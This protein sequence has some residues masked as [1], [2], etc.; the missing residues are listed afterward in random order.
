MSELNYKHQW[1]GLGFADMT[2]AQAEEWVTVSG[3][4]DTPLELFVRKIV[5]F[6][7]DQPYGEA[8]EHCPRMGVGEPGTRAETV[9]PRLLHHWTSLM[10][11]EM[12]EQEAEGWMSDEGRDL[13][14]SPHSLAV[15][16]ALCGDPF[17]HAGLVCGERAVYVDE[18]D[19]RD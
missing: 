18:G 17:E 4:A 3:T 16:C 6:R 7:C 2:Q 10:T 12:S 5:C 19:G 13:Q 9:D 8:T 14:L 15:A 11:I 1:I